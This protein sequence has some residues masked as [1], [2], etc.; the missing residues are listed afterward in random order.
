MIEKKPFKIIQ[1]KSLIW[2][3]YS[4]IFRPK[5]KHKKEKKEKSTKSSQPLGT[6]LL[7]TC[8]RSSYL[9][10]SVLSLCCTGCKRL[11]RLALMWSSNEPQEIGRIILL[12][13]I[14]S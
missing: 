10:Y 7:N 4:T 14:G 3:C 2:F 11:Y 5:E 13:G 8:G 12:I 6:L 9:V 1:I